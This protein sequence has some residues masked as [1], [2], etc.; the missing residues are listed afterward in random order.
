MDSENFS[1]F[2]GKLEL[3]KTIEKISVIYR[4]Y[5]DNKNF[6]Y[7]IVRSNRIIFYPQRWKDRSP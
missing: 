3:N 6:I 5:N 1:L 2:N 7:S 4:S